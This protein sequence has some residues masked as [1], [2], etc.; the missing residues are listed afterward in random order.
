M[1]LAAKEG[2]Q[3]VVVSAQVWGGCFPLPVPLFR[4]A[5]PLGLTDGGREGATTGLTAALFY[6]SQPP[7]LFLFLSIL[8][9]RAEQVMSELSELGE[10]EAAEYLASMGVTESGLQ[11]L[12]TASALGIA[13]GPALLFFFF[14]RPLPIHH[15]RTEREPSPGRWPCIRRVSRGRPSHALPSRSLSQASYSAL[16]LRTYFTCGEKETRA[17]TIKARL[18]GSNSRAR[19]PRRPLPAWSLSAL[20]PRL[21]EQPAGLARLGTGTGS[22]A[23]QNPRRAPFPSFCYGQAGMTAPQAAGV[24]HSDFEKGF[25]RC[26]SC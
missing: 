23:R 22:F 2:A 5:A 14:S 13:L 1:D 26:V 20:W 12:I 15:R 3:V 4:S 17:W 18:L 8:R 7:V 11:A 25:I 9:A 16:G 19:G 21:S 10:A 6:R 24:I